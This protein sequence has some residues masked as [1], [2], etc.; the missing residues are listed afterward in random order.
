MVSLQEAVD[1][2]DMRISDICAEKKIK[3]YYETVTDSSGCFNVPKMWGLKKKLNLSSQSVP[4]AKK[5]KSG[6]LITTKNGLLALYK[7]TYMDRLSHKPIREDYEQLKELKE[8]LFKLRYEISSRNKLED[9]KVEQIE[10]VCKSLKNS[11]AR[12]ECG[13]IYELFKPPYAGPDVYKSLCK[14]FNMTKQELEIPEFFELMSIT[15][16]YKNRGSRSDLS[17]ERGIFNVITQISSILSTISLGSFHFDIAMVLREALFINSIMSNSEIWHNVKL[18]HVQSLEKL[19]M[20]LLRKIVNAH[21]K[22]ACEALFFELGK[23]PLRFTLSK[24]RLMYLWQILH[25][26]TDELTWKVYQAQKLKTSRGDWYQIIQTERENLHI[27]LSDEEIE[28]MSREKYKSIVEKHI[29]SEGLK[30]L[31]GLA[32][33]HSKSDLIVS[34]KL[35]KKPYFSD[36]RFSKEDV[37]ILFSLRTKMT[38]CKTNFKNQFG[39]NNLQC[40]ICQDKN[41]IEDED[42]ILICPELTDGKSEVQFTDVYGD[43]DSQYSAVKAFKKII[44]R[45]NV[46]IEMMEKSS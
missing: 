33:P 10:K 31:C 14:L 2:L 9:W 41:S 22:T 1:S 21:S 16:L 38:N 12:D 28:K 35:E 26:D 24:R 4:S 34:D 23:L 37:Q 13:F 36:R 25:R 39:E 45:R 20:Q 19:D 30:Y 29:Q 5:D 43:V 46:Y 3:D 27:T 11:K 44:R 6:N 42:H 32:A 7:Q 8:T 18:G 15:S 17:N 40:R